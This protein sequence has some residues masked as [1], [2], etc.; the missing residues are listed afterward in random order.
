[1][2]KWEESWINKPWVESAKTYDDPLGKAKEL[3]Q[4]HANH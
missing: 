4:K 3:I 1:M 2:L